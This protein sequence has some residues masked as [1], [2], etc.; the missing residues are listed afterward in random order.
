[1]VTLGVVI[2]NCI[3]SIIQSKPK[4]LI[5]EKIVVV[6]NGSTDN[7]LNLLAAFKE[8]TIIKN[9]T[10]CGFGKACNIGA[11]LVDSSLILFLN[12]DTVLRPDTLDKSITFFEENKERLN[13]GILGTQ[14]CGEDGRIQQSCSRFPSGGRV[15]ADTIG[16]S[17]IFNHSGTH[18]KDFDHN[19]S[20]VVDQVIGAYLLLE[21]KLFEKL[22][23]F[24]ESFFVYFEEV[25]FSYRAKKIL[26]NS[27][28]YTGTSAMHI[29][30]GCSEQV[31]AKRLFYSLTS[32]LVY[33]KK[34]FRPFDYMMV[35]ATTLF[36]ELVTRI[37][38]ALLKLDL[39]AVKET[40]I[41]YKM[42]Y[43]GSDKL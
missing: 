24:D 22:H 17:R 29:G 33:A 4:N 32:R 31:K 27:F 12:P 23:G 6:D 5:L 14:L 37:V 7:S 19:K 36:L 9:N 1:M 34:H 11:S 28:Y 38:F 15:F 2:V 43:F 16:I 3:N 13:F 8:I 26:V 42:L 30:G 41:A 25:D 21:K 10:N 40:A 35:A 18:M 39:A 20:M